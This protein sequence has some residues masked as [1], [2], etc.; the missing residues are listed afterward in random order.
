MTQDQI[1][2]MQRASD[3]YHR[4]IPDSYKYQMEMVREKLDRLQAEC[5]HKYPDG[6]SAIEGGIMFCSTCRICHWSDL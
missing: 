4:K 1:D 6:S 2:A 5:D 3:A